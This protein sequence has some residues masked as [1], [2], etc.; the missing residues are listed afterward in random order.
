MAM[1]NRVPVIDGHTE[2]VFVRFRRPATTAQVR[3]AL[4][5]YRCEAQEL[6]LPSAPEEWYAGGLQLGAAVAC[7]DASLSPTSD[8]LSLYHSIHVFPSEADR[9]QPRLDRDRGNGFT[10][11]V[12]RLRPSAQADG[13]PTGDDEPATAFQ[14]TLLSH[15]TI[16]G[17]AGS[18]ILNAELAWHHGWLGPS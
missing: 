12:G 16:L 10:V 15:N 14:F 8:A 5:R 18:A 11:S 7:A 17:A 13:V 3:A 4:E 1:C 2:S 9:P 6:G